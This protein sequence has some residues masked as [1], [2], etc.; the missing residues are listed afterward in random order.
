[1]VTLTSGAIDVTRGPLAPGERF[2]VRTGDAEIDVR[3]TAFRV[4]ADRNRIR[5]VVVAEGTLEVRYAGFSAVIPSGGSWRATDPP[6]AATPPP[7]APP[8]T[9]ARVAMARRAP[10]RVAKAP[11]VEESPPAVKDTPPPP[12]AGATLPASSVEFAAAMEAL[13]RGDFNDGVVRLVTFTRAHPE[14]ARADEAD[15]LQAIALQRAGRAH[16]AV[17]AAKRYLGARPEGAHRS[18]AQRIAGE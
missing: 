9:A 10:A 3:G 8:A 2:V 13:G 16:D 5:G 11:P 7:S 6:V 15:Y 1:V 4:E 14:D 17:A 18:D 12:V